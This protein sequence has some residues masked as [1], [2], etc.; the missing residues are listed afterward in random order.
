MTRR[1]SARDR[2]P[3]GSSKDHVCFDCHHDGHMLCSDPHCRCWC[4]DERKERLATE[5]ERT[6]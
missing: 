1:K 6:A 5:K 4:Q 2:I 3:V